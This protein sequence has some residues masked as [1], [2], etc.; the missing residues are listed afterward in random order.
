M[1]QYVAVVT[2]LAVGATMG[3]ALATTTS[4][5]QNYQVIETEFGSGSTLESCSGSYCTRASIGNMSGAS[6]S[7]GGNQVVFGEIAADSDPMLEVSIQPGVSDLGVLRTDRPSTK[8]STIEV[9]TYLSGGYTLQIKGK[10]PKA[11]SHTFATSSTPVVSAPGTEFFGINIAKNTTPEIG[12]DVEQIPSGETS[13]G[14]A[15]ANYAQPNLFMYKDGDV[16]ARSNEDS[17]RTKYTVSMVINVS[18]ATP[19]GHFTTDF[20]AVVVPAF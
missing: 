9:R 4:N 12:S 15:T 7:A 13:F 5:S 1:G 19:A 18:N 16:V 10:P 17:G 8:T 20:S 3:T 6:A 14:F 2:T 11:G